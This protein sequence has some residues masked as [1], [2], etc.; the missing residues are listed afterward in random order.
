VTGV[1]ILVFWSAR[2]WL[3]GAGVDKIGE[4][5]EQIWLVKGFVMG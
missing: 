1:T 5:I 3:F 2:F 4:M